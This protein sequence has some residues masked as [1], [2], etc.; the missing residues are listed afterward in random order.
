MEVS[1]PPEV[2][3]SI[4]F[5]NGPNAGRQ[6]LT[7]ADYE[8]TLVIEWSTCAAWHDIYMPTHNR[9]LADSFVIRCSLGT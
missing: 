1:L 5:I 2:A 8:L 9:S 7:S 6:V 4:G 3:K